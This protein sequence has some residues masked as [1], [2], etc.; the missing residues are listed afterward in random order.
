MPA[1]IPSIRFSARED[2]AAARETLKINPRVTVMEL[3]GMNYFL[4]DTRTGSPNEYN[5][6]ERTKSPA[7]I[8]IICDWVNL[9]TRSSVKLGW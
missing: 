8:K 2:L 5:N 3:Q 4:Q 6:I 9:Q 7:A 1:S